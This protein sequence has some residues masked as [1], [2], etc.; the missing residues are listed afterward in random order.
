MATSPEPNHGDAA[1]AVVNE[2]GGSDDESIAAALRAAGL[3]IEPMG[4]SLADQIGDL[5]ARGVAVVAVAGG[6]GTLRTAAS[7]LAGTEAA[8]LPVAAGTKNHFA[9]TLG[10]DTVKESIAALERGDVVE[11]PLAE[12]DGQRFL[13]TAVIG[14]YPEL[15]AT[16]ERLRRLLP[17]R[18]AAALAALRHAP[19]HHPFEVT[20]GDAVERVWMI[21]IGN[22]RY[23]L[24]P[25]TVVERSSL[26]DG[27]VDVRLLRADRRFARFRVAWALFSRQL[28]ES[29]ELDC[30]VRDRPVR[31]RLD[32]GSADPNDP[33]RVR[34][35]LD[36]EPVSVGRDV[37]VVPDACRVR[38]LVGGLGE[39]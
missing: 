37:V 14:W 2:R 4:D 5:V 11:V 28:D 33:S 7:A 1:V 13:N 12:L 32:A 35:A 21:W 39:R 27:V 22:G 26:T 36:A 6:D 38:V 24:A 8:L 23:G 18:V 30:V 9:R 19:V 34:A 20:I 25:D 3:R 16:R 29:P 15:V 10:L 17:R 31:L